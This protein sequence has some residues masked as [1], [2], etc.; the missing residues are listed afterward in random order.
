VIN[1]FSGFPNPSPS[2]S[3]YHVP[4][5]SVLSHVQF[6]FN[7]PLQPSVLVHGAPLYM[8]ATVSSQSSLL[9]R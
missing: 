6:A 5:S 7:V 8:V 3:S 1:G 4:T 2:L 9:S